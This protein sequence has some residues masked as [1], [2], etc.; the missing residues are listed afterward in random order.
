MHYFV[1]CLNRS[2]PRSVIEKCVLAKAVLLILFIN[3]LVVKAIGPFVCY[4][5]HYELM[6]L[7]ILEELSPR[8]KVLL[9]V[10][11]SWICQ[12]RSLPAAPNPIHNVSRDRLCIEKGGSGPLPRIDLLSP[13]ILYGFSRGVVDTYAPPRLPGRILLMLQPWW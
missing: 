11:G 9:G 4:S 3:L 13:N 12:P 8:T 6:R 1:N 7:D 10:A 2:I 5:I